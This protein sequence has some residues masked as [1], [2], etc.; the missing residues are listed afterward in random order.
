VKTRPP[1][2]LAWAS[3]AAVATAL[4]IPSGKLG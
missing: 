2:P 3:G 1:R 4:M